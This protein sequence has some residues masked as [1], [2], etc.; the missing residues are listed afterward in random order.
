MKNYRFILTHSSGSLTLEFNPVNWQNFNFIMRRSDRY[1]SILRSGQIED[2]ELPFDGKAYIDSIYDTYGIDTDITCQIQ[3]LNK[4]TFAYVTL[5]TGII[6]LSEY[7]RRKDT[8]SIKII[9][10]SVM[11]KFASRD[12]IEVALNRTTD[13]DGDALS[14][15]TFLNSF[16][17][18]GVDIE[19]K[20]EYDDSTN[21]IELTLAD[22]EVNAFT[23]NLGV[24]SDFD[25]NEIGDSATLPGVNLS[26]PV[27]TEG[28]VYT[29]DT[30][31][32]IDVRFR[33]KTS[34]S[35]SV[36]VVSATTWG[37]A[38]TVKT[39]KQGAT[40]AIAL[41]GNGSGND[42]YALSGTYDSGWIEETLTDGQTIQFY[43][44]WSGSGTGDH[45]PEFTI[46]PI[47]VAVFQITDGFASTPIN[48]PLV[49]ELGAKILEIIT[50]VSDPLNS[51]ILGRTDS[52]PRDYASDGD[53]SLIGVASGE[54]LRRFSFTN[55]PMK[56]SFADYFKSVDALC[57]LGCWYNGTE[58]Q[59]LAKDQFYKDSEI[60]DLGDVREL[61]ISVAQDHY[62]NKILC[63]YRD[64]LSY[65]D[66]N[67]NQNFNV[68]VE[69]ANDGKR[70]SGVLDIQSVYHGDDYGI[71][72][73]RRA[74]SY[75]NYSDDIDQDE[76]IFF[77]WG[78]RS[79]PF[80]TVP[81]SDL[82]DVTGMY[83]PD[84]RLNLL[85]TPRRNLLNHLNQLSIPLWKSEGDMNYISKQFELDLTT[86][87]GIGDPVIS[88]I[89]DLAYADMEE[90]LFYPELYNFNAPLDNDTILQLLTDPHGYVTFTFEG[91]DYTGFII[92]V[93]SEPFNRQ[94]NWTLIRRNPNRT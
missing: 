83:A 21:E 16:T 8:T 23:V 61:E 75:T 39:G 85:I 42:T 60:I 11:A 33:I 37:W 45:T 72:L 28:V 27:G 82:N 87:D 54:M 48:M 89:A 31:D 29:N 84:T 2:I 14:S 81:G 53:Y 70:L 7:V 18:G 59:I 93:S 38:F 43:H 44:I 57:N 35:G 86:Q 15:Y 90:P 69:Y 88:E 34:V 73:A 9:D 71:E 79:G 19:E 74:S 3:Y 17:V 56:T 51:S 10:S 25:I 46:A 26:T 77:I 40:N 41:S 49:H 22:V 30:G 78:K 58:F 47:F 55:K 52:E 65:D 4:S 32:N 6:D 62:F 24:A 94:G 91:T 80:I 68:P 64:S 66:V 50:G 92:E 13:L 12:E 63:G 36:D 5:F 76:Q 67:G 20:A 1:H